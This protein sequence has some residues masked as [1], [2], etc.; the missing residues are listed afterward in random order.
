[1]SADINELLKKLNRLPDEL[2]EHIYV[3]GSV[4]RGNPNPGDLDIVLDFSTERYTV[5]EHGIVTGFADM[6][7]FS[8]VI[9]ML[10][11]APYASF[12]PFIKF[13]DVLLCRNPDATHFIKAKNAKAMWVDMQKTMKPLS[14]ISLYP[15]ENKKSLKP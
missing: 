9:K 6:K 12:D 15:E 11:S 3:F 1:M 2:K 5:K 14:V 13:K 7:K 4:A 10:H 8:P